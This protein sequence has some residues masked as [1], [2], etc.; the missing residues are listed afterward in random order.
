MKGFHGQELKYNDDFRYITAN[1][2]IEEGT[3]VW[4]ERFKDAYYNVE[5]LGPFIIEEG[6]GPVW[7]GPKNQNNPTT[8]E[9]VKIVCTITGVTHYVTHGNFLNEC[10]YVMNEE[11]LCTDAETK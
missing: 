6:W 2:Y 4:I 11:K 1:E 10:Y 3:L 5:V 8:R 7:F 9:Y